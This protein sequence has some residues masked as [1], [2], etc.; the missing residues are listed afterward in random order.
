MNK[1]TLILVKLTNCPF[2]IKFIPVFDKVS[3]LIKEEPEFKNTEINIKTYDYEK[4]KE[5]FE[6][7][8]LH[9][10]FWAFGAPSIFIDCTINSKDNQYKKI[11]PIYPENN[12]E[13]EHKKTSVKFLNTI[14]KEYKVIVASQQ[15]GNND[16]YYKNK[17]L[18]YKNKYLI[19]KNNN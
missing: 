8:N 13:E 12:N 4:E 5:K 15:G 18:K 17:Y 14:I 10:A 3:E 19:L 1:V 6:K 7:E 16:I 11:E 9:L 2:C